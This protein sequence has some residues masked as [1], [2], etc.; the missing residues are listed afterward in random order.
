MAS[1]RSSKNNISHS[2]ENNIKVN[3]APT[4]FTGGVLGQSCTIHHNF[5]ETIKV[6]KSLLNLFA[7]I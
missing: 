7:E 1:K 2:N 3:I 4:T 6:R 5:T